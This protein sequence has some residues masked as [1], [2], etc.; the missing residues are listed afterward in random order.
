LGKLQPI[1]G[2]AQPESL[3]GRFDSRRRKLAAFFGLLTKIVCVAHA[4]MGFQRWPQLAASSDAFT[5]ILIRLIG[6]RQPVLVAKARIVLIQLVYE[7]EIIFAGLHES[8]SRAW[9]LEA[10]GTV[11]IPSLLS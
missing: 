8:D 2:Q 4:L 3:V 6:E 1:L 5:V 10:L 9:M 7:V 11:L